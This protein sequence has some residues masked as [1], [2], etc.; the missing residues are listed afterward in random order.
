MQIGRL[1]SRRYIVELFINPNTI[2]VLDHYKY[3][4]CPVK[5]FKYLC[6]N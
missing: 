4:D 3:D 6:R 1:F 5:H 2:R